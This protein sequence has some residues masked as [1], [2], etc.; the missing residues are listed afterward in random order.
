MACGVDELLVFRVVVKWA[1]NLLVDG[2]GEDFLL[3][4]LVLVAFVAFD[5][6]EALF[7]I[8]TYLRGH[9]K[10]FGEKVLLVEDAVVVRGLDVAI[11]IE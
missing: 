7:V 6:S 11:H 8:E 3:F 4:E 10:D 2:D 5:D 9:E 1:D